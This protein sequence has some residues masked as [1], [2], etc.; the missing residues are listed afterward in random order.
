MVVAMIILQ[1]ANEVRSDA[2]DVR[3]Y[4]Q[5]YPQHGF[6][7]GKYGIPAILN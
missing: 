1:N 2:D 7:Q 4:I 5:E 6:P 3:I